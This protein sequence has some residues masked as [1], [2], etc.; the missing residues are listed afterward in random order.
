MDLKIKLLKQIMRFG[1]VGGSAA[2]VNFSIVVMLVESGLLKQ[3][4]YANMVAFVF[5]FQVSYF[6]HRYWTFS[7]TVTEHHVAMARLLLVSSANFFANEGLFYF[8][9]NTFHMPYMLALLLVLAILPI[10]TFTFSKLWVFR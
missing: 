4:L 8:F 10:V 3:P 5:A 7:D 1:I 9:L 6:G 2:F